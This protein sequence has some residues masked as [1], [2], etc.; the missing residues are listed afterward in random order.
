MDNPEAEKHKL[1]DS[2]RQRCEA[3]ARDDLETLE[4]L[5]S[6]DYLHIH[7]NGV[8]EDRDAYFDRLGGA[9]HRRTERGALD[10]RLYGRVAVVTGTLVTTIRRRTEDPLVRITGFATQV[11]SQEPEHGPWRHV[12]FQL[13]STAPVVEVESR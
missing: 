12:L 9:V 13:T 10:V 8:V 11:W 3:L 1:V 4:A 5:T 6:S 2:E 7:A